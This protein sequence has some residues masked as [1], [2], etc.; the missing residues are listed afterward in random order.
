MNTEYNAVVNFRSE[1]AGLKAL[2]NWTN[3]DLARWL[4]C[5]AS[6]VSELYRDPRKAT[7]MYILKIHQRFRE[8]RA[9][10]FRELL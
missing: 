6:T 7:G 2:L 10:Q 4:G 8:E 9:K 3:E 1:M 5:R